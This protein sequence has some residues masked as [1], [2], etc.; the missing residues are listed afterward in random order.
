MAPHRAVIQLAAL[1][2]FIQLGHTGPIKSKI[3]DGH[4]ADPHSKPWMAYIT[5]SNQAGETLM[6]GG[7]LVRRDMVMTAAHCFG[8]NTKVSLGLHSLSEKNAKNTYAVR[9]SHRHSNYESDTHDSDIML[10]QLMDQVHLNDKIQVIAL[11][12]R[13][14]RVPVGTM[15]N[16]AG[17]GKT[18]H[19][20][21]SQVLLEVNVTV[22]GNNKC[23]SVLDL[24]VSDAMMCAGQPGTKGDAAQGDSGGPLVCGGV[25]TGIVSFGNEK[26][27][28]VYT[29]ISSF[30]PWIRKIMP[31]EL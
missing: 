22:V 14:K 24:P 31:D 5:Y 29:Q 17:W 11:P 4:E 3:I 25:A 15:C 8:R 1:L 30:L 12:K 20:P 7:F 26:P 19:G 13:N 2:C 9:L 21:G 27:P 10:L 23:R 18:R 16:V 6:C 28:G